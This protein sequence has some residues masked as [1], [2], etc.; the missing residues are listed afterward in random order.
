MKIDDEKSNKLMPSANQA[1]DEI[2]ERWDGQWHTQRTYLGAIVEIK[3]G[4]IKKVKD[5]LNAQ[6]F[7][8]VRHIES[9]I[10]YLYLTPE[11]PT[12]LDKEG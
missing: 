1:E 12:R 10:K 8:K 2:E 11:R 7:I 9:S 6:P 3:A 4:D 5:W